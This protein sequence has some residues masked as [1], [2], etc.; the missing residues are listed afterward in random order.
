M[1]SRNEKIG[2]G[3]GL[4]SRLC[5]AFDPGIMMVSSFIIKFSPNT[6]AG[7]N[8]K[9]KRKKGK[10]KV[11]YSCLEHVDLA[12]ES[13][14]DETQLAPLMEQVPEEE[15]LSTPCEYCGKPAAYLVTDSCSHTECGQ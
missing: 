10:C 4:L 14:T 9:S 6:W 2:T 7:Y 1:R 8:R 13:V 3:L 5:F 11:I 15:K 12:L